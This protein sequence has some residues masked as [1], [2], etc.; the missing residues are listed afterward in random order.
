MIGSV[1]G[2]E[3]KQIVDNL[4]KKAK[5][6]GIDHKLLFEINATRERLM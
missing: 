6:L 2:K 3:D 4:K 5:E 1:R